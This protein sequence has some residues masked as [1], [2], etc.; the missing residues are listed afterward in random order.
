MDLITNAS[1]IEKFEPS[2]LSMS[3]EELLF[4]YSLIRMNNIQT[5]IECGT[6]FGVSTAWAAMAL[7]DAGASGKVWTVDIEDRTGSLVYEGTQVEPRINTVIG[8]FTQEFR[9]IWK[10]ARK[11]TPALVLLDGANGYPAYKAA[12]DEVFWRLGEEDWVVMHDTNGSKGSNQLAYELSPRVLTFPGT[13]GM[14][15]CKC[16]L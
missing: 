13:F 8:D 11:K 12:W 3:K 9:G 7:E 10:R 16:K 14:G 4:Y 5:V 6:A 15:V 1:L 2:A